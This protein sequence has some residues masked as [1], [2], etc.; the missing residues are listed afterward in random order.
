MYGKPSP[1]GC[2]V[3]WS[4]WYKGIF[5]RSLLELS[6]MIFFDNSGIEY[7]SGENKLVKKFYYISYSG[8]ER[9]Y[10]TDFYL[11][12]FLIFVEC[13]YKKMTHTR[14]FKLKK[15]AVKDSGET[16]VVLTERDIKV[17]P[18]EILLRMLLN[19]EIKFTQKYERK[20]AERLLNEYC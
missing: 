3:G 1:H 19:E 10:R 20:F 7:I 17:L 11:Q 14:E 8:N 9:T 13:K 15:K 4:G 16:L 5:F 18:E 2:G 6:T 12:K